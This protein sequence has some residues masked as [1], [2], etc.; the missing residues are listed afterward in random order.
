MVMPLLCR[1]E[2]MNDH[3]D[4]Q[5]ISQKEVRYDSQIVRFDF[6]IVLYDTE[7]VPFDFKIVR[8]EVEIVHYDLENTRI[9][10]FEYLAALLLALAL[11]LLVIHL[12]YRPHSRS[13]GNFAAG[14]V[15]PNH[16]DGGRRA[17]RKVGSSR[18]RFTKVAEVRG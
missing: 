10:F 2:T 5:W 12:N 18:R 17:N 15:L 14:T 4:F 6:K 16:V 13:A 8:S 11:T 3:S 7:I 1:I 9:G